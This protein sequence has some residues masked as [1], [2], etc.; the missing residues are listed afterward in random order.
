MSNFK[1]KILVVDDMQSMRSLIRTILHNQGFDNVIETSNGH[2]ALQKLRAVKFDLVISDWDMPVMDGLVLLKEIRG[3]AD[4]QNLPFIM[5]TA[6]NQA[7]KVKQIIAARVNDYISK[8]FTPEVLLTK[9][10]RV[11]GF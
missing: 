7:D 6:N 3:S 1:T 4:L 2:N 11:L 9:V 8:P 5:L 10:K